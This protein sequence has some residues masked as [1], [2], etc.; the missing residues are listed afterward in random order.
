MAQASAPPQDHAAAT[1]G[2]IVIDE[3]LQWCRLQEGFQRLRFVFRCR[4]PHAAGEPRRVEAENL[5]KH[6][7][8]PWPAAIAGKQPSPRAPQCAGIFESRCRRRTDIDISDSLGGHAVRQQSAQRWIGS[9]VCVPGTPS[10]RRRRQLPEGRHRCPDS[11]CGHD[12]RKRVH[13]YRVT[14][15]RQTGC[16][17]R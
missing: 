6:A 1:K 15:S 14:Q 9:V 10:R 2:V 17:R 8:I 12:R 5:G 3:M 16:R 7:Q 4:S 11:G 13:S